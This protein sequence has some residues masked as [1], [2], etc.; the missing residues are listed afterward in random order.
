MFI[1]RG[2]V[3]RRK[4]YILG[5]EVKLDPPKFAR[6]SGGKAKFKCLPTFAASCFLHVTASEKCSLAFVQERGGD[7]HAFVDDKA[8]FLFGGEIGGVDV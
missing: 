5:C 1:T 3:C 6:A 2:K 7:Y 8:C 4:A